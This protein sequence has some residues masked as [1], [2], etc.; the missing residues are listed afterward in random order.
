MKKQ[1]QTVWKRVQSKVY[2]PLIDRLKNGETIRKEGSKYY[3]T[4]SGEEISDETIQ[5][6]ESRLKD[7]NEISLF[8]EKKKRRGT[9]PKLGK[10]GFTPPNGFR[11]GRP[12]KTAE[13]GIKEIKPVVNNSPKRQKE[14]REGRSVIEMIQF[15]AWKLTEEKQI[16]FTSKNLWTKIEELFGS[17]PICSPRVYT[18]YL[19][20]RTVNSK[21]RKSWTMNHGER[22]CE[23][24]DK[25]DFFFRVGSG[26]YKLYEPKFDGTWGIDKSNEVYEVMGPV[27]VRESNLEESVAELVSV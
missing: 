14:R 21:G 10:T 11:R 25:K 20:Q 12:P 26:V 16:V 7:G 1:N 8:F 4:V 27:A 23:T 19:S 5:Y 3:W 18:S 2:G 13:K 6:F 15:A 9:P 22:I 24:R 17:E